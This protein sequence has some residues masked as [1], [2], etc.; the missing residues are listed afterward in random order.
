MSAVEHTAR[1]MD[2]LAWFNEHGPIQIDTVT[3][4]E[5]TGIP[6]RSLLR[7]TKRMEALALIVIER[8][9]GFGVGREAN[10]YRA[11]VTPDAWRRRSQETLRAQ[12]K[13]ARKERE[14]RAKRLR[15]EA[16]VAA[17]NEAA[18]TELSRILETLDAPDPV[19]VELERS[20]VA[21]MT[22]DPSEEDLV[23][24]WLGGGL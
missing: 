18:A 2:L 17:V 15:S 20:I 5:R 6:E 9:A 13:A 4:A 10:R 8:P 23:D 3:L 22:G 7:H 12:A 24:A 14:A 19:I 11:V 16:E 1:F 21:Q